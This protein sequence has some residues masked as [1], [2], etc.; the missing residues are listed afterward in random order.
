MIAEVESIQAV[1]ADAI[2]VVPLVWCFIGRGFPLLVVAAGV[3][4]SDVVIV[5]ILIVEEGGRLVIRIHQGRD[6]KSSLFRDRDVGA[7][8]RNW[9]RVAPCSMIHCQDV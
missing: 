5:V 6:I 3:V 1:T 2:V 8:S 4:T 7:C 9:T